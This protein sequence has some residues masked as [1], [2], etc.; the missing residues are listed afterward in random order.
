MDALRHYLYV[1][2]LSML[3]LVELRGS[4]LMGAGLDLPWVGN[5]IVSVIGNMLPIPFIL[6]FIRKILA[7]MHTT[8]HFHKIAEWLE[9]KAHSKSDQVLRYASLGLM[10][11][12]AIPLPGTGAW[13]GALI[14]ALLDMRMKY[15]LPSIFVGVVIAAFIMSGASYGFLAFLSFLL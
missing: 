15:A 13:T 11:F 10:L 12:V 6:L 4:I 9:N 2:F 8:K 1:F 14:A 5:F 3:P 7:W